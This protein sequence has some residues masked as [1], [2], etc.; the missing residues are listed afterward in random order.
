MKKTLVVSLAMLLLLA[1]SSLCLAESVKTEKAQ[2]KKTVQLPTT[3]K[4]VIAPALRIPQEK[5]Y[6]AAPPAASP[7][8]LAAEKAA[9]PKELKVGATIYFRWQKYL[10]NGGSAVNNFDLDRAYI[11]FRK[12][13]DKGATGRLTLDIS[14][15]PGASKQNLFDYIKYAYV[16]MPL[17][18]TNLKLGLQQTVWID[19]ADKLLN[20][21]WIAKS[22]IDNEGV[23][24]SADF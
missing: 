24:S 15:I 7:K 10:Q 21:R 5:V 16:E 12:E 13:M 8:L 23:M 19:W 9:E 22:L 17:G 4:P 1:A 6:P 18:M 3:K 14:R 2:K 11:D 20:L